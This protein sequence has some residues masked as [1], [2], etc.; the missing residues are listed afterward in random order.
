MQRIRT[1]SLPVPGVQ[2]IICAITE[3]GYA[4][5]HSIAK[6]FY[7]LRQ[8][9]GAPITYAA[10]RSF[11]SQEVKCMP[12]HSVHS[13]KI[14]N[15]KNQ[16]CLSPDTPQG[17]WRAQ[18]HRWPFE[19]NKKSV[20]SVQLSSLTPSQSQS[21]F[22]NTGDLAALSMLSV[23]LKAN[24]PHFTPL[25]SCQQ[26]NIHKVMEASCSSLLKTHARYIADSTHTRQGIC[27]PLDS[28]H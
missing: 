7:S 25:M 4:L 22:T 28:D 24:N 13:A 14:V 11:K 10:N 1:G 27:L 19:A 8:R 12:F 3:L 23:F 2:V 26:E 16:T 17:S 5:V 15:K 6:T 21:I 9:V 20:F 18:H